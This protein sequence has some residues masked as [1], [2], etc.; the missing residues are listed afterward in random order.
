MRR[1]RKERRTRCTATSG[2]PTWPKPTT[3]VCAYS[4]GHPEG[5]HRWVIRKLGAGIVAGLAAG[6]RL[7]ELTVM[8]HHTSWTA[9]Q[10][11]RA[12]ESMGGRMSPQRRGKSASAWL[13][14]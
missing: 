14:S 2:F 4:F 1:K 8:V 10:F 5:S 11:A 3:F 13:N 6:A 9:E 12:A 7:G